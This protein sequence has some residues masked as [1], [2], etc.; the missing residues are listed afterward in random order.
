M[1]MENTTI[2]EIQFEEESSILSK[3]CVAPKNFEW[4]KNEVLVVL[5]KVENGEGVSNLSSI[6]ICGKNMVEWTLMATPNCEH[7]I[8]DYK[9]D[10]EL[11]EYLKN[12]KTDKK[13]IFL[14]YSDIPYL[15]NSTFN[16]IMYY[17]SSQNLNS[18]KLPRGFVFK[19]EYLLSMS[20][21]NSSQQKSFG[22]RD[23]ER[24]NSARQISNFFNYMNKKIKRYHAENGVIFFGEETIFID[25]DVEIDRGVII[26]PNN[27][28]KGE[29]YIGKNV[30]LESGNFIEDSIISDN[31]VLT[32]SYV[33]KSKIQEGQ[34]IGPFKSIESES[35]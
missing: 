14:T 27:I 26:H 10:L 15:K 11:L 16:E 8:I 20:Y 12:L 3:I 4:I 34:S 13:Y 35:V 29:S 25:A 7:R 32:A 30:I 33:K 5:V 17:F 22:E 9:Q 23:F 19:T 6:K 21:L 2:T 1:E 31:C 24:V 18:L 28:I